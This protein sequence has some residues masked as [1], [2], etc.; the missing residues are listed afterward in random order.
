V[1]DLEP[2]QSFLRIALSECGW[3]VEECIASDAWWFREQWHICSVWSPQCSE[4]YLAFLVDPMDEPESKN[5]LWHREVWAISA[6]RERLVDKKHVDERALLSLGSHWKE[7]VPGL[8]GYLHELRIAR[9][10]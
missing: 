7:R 8:M 2:I 3:T 6:T 4:A 5:H 10:G 9:L 1:R